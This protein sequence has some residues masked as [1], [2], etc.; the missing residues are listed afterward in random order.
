MKCRQ[1][2]LDVFRSSASPLAATQWHGKNRGQSMALE[3]GDFLKNFKKYYP[4]ID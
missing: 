2:G 1:R 4:S 3:G